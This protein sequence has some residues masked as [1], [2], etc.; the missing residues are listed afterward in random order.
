MGGG[1]SSAAGGAGTPAEG[2]VAAAAGAVSEAGGWLG[3]VLLVL[4]SS[5]NLISS[6]PGMEDN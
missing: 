5:D 2:A 3:T 4:L 1:V 6:I